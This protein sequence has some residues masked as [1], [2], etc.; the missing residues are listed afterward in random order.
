[1]ER[2]VN[3]A[4]ELEHAS[5]MAIKLVGQPFYKTSLNQHKN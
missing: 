2:I 1:M 3:K 4:T 5:F